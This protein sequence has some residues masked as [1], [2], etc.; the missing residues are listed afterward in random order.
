MGIKEIELMSIMECGHCG[1]MDSVR[2]MQG[3]D[4]CGRMV[5]ADCRAAMEECPGDMEEWRGMGDANP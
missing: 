3:C 2:S 5:C 4:G 1:R